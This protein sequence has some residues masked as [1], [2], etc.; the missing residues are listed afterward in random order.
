MFADGAMSTHL[1][2]VPSRRAQQPLSPNARNTFVSLRSLLL[3]AE[4]FQ[5]A[6]AG[7]LAVLFTQVQTEGE[8]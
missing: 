6:T 4:Q 3:A 7:G 2:N 1:K 8:R 5:T